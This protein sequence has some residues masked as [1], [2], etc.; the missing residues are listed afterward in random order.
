MHSAVETAMLLPSVSRKRDRGEGRIS[1]GPHGCTGGAESSAV[2]GWLIIDLTI[3]LVLPLPGD[4]PMN[5]WQIR[6]N[7]GAM[8]D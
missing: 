6:I 1:Q 3:L 5:I 7:Y 2:G 4:R 8:V